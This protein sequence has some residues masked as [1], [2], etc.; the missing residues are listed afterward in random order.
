LFFGLISL[1]LYL[2]PTHA[3]EKSKNKPTS[4][5]SIGTNYPIIYFKKNR[6]KFLEEELTWQIT[7]ALLGKKD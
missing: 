3:A 4:I 6:T 7:E 5:K 1:S 2:F